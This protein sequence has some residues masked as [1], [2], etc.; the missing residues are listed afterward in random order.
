MHTRSYRT[1]VKSVANETAMYTVDLEAYLANEV[2]SPAQPAIEKLR[3]LTVLSGGEREAL[4]RYVIA[5]W[6]RV[7]SGRMR[8]AATIPE[9]ADSVNAEI[10]RGLEDAATEDPSLSDIAE[11]RRREVN[12]L[13]AKYKQ[14]PPDHFWHYTVGTQATPRMVHGLLEMQWA[15]LVSEREHFITSDNPVFFFA[16][17][18]IGSPQSELSVPLS[19]R[20]ALWA[21]RSRAPKPYFLPVERSVVLEINRRTARNTNRFLYTKQESPWALRFGAK[22]HALSR[23]W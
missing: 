6:K 5:M 18:G 3:E 4:A 8:V 13:I 12:A 15:I 2:E 11:S 9:V 19:S 20:V 21:A 14:D 22:K 10:Q 7:P 23:L 17:E 1:Q 16:A